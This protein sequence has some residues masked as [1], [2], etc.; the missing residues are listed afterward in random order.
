MSASKLRTFLTMLGVIIGI[1]AVII[2]V[3]IV[4]GFSDDLVSTFESIGTNSITVTLRGRG[5]NIKLS[6]EDMIALADENPKLFSA[7]TP[8]VTINAT[9]KYGTSNTIS[10][11]YG[12]NEDYAKISDYAVANGRFITYVDVLKRNNVCCIGTYIAS[13]LFPG[14]SPVGKVIKINGEAFSVIGVLE[15]EGDSSESSTD[16]MIIIPYSVASRLSRNAY[17]SSY[18]FVAKDTSVIEEAKDVIDDFLFDIYKDEDAYSIINLTALVDQIE[19]IMNTLSLIL[20]G[21]AAIS[22][23]VGGIGIMNIMLVSVVERTREIG[24]RKAIGG[25]RRDILSQFV[26]EA[27]ITSGLGGIIG[28]ILGSV[29]TMALAG[30][31]GISGSVSVGAVFLSF[32]VSV[33]IGI[34]FGYFPAAK[35]SKLNPIDALRHD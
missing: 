8:K 10:T 21:I 22:L 29:A 24:I 14:T 20:A 9:A 12:A 13:E 7:A 16:N 3:S 1:A 31:L 26:I 17:I 27:T 30:L 19:E 28:I 23:L 25:K 2:L 34:M 6:A 11:V 33:F 4:Q 15:E 32:S 18:T 35:A 5:G